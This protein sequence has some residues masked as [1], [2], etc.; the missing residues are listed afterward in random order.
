M[1]ENLTLLDF[2]VSYLIGQYAG[3]GEALSLDAVRAALDIEGIP[4][5]EWAGMTRRVLIFHRAVVAALPKKE[6]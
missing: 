4:R 3:M 2:Y 6:K 1:P 5:D